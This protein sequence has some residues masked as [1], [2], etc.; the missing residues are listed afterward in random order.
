MTPP[1]KRIR[2]SDSYFTL[3]DTLIHPNLNEKF[4]ILL[5]V[6]I[7]K[8]KWGWFNLQNRSKKLVRT[9]LNFMTLTD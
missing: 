8:I 5:K 2:I 9:L 4:G 6:E 1:S 7:K 3:S